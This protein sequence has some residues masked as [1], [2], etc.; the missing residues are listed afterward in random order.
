VSRSARISIILA[1]LL[2][3][4][5]CDQVTK[6][7]A[8]SVLRLR[9]PAS[10]LGDLFRIQY[11]ENVGAFL[12]LGANLPEHY[13]FWIFSVIVVAFLGVGLVYLFLK[14]MP[15][16]STVGF[17]L[18]LGGGV[19]NS[20]DRITLGHVTDFLNMGIGS[21]RT[22]IFNVADMAVMAGIGIM[23]FETFTQPQ[24][25]A[26]DSAPPKSTG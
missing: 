9:P 18:I 21:L 7:F 3:T 5:G 17:A 26:S 15:A 16:L 14:P 13:R 25:Q 1:L 20:I 19:G 2:T 11:S 6:V 8:R 12:S 24:T 23:M 4:V 10:Y 22:G